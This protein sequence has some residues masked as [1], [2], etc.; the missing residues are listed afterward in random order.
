[1]SDRPEIEIQRQTAFGDDGQLEVTETSVETS[2]EDFGA[3]VDHRDRDSRLDQPEACEFGVDD[4][5]EVEQTSEGD[6][7]TLFADTDEDQQTLA[8]DDAA[9]RC[10]FEE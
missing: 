10:L 6:Q 5:P 9:A 1:M 2:L 8:G 7:S 3:D 4:R